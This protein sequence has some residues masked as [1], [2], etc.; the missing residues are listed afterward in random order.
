MLDFLLAFARDACDDDAAT[1]GRRPAPRPALDTTIRGSVRVDGVGNFTAFGDG[2]VRVHYPRPTH[3]ALSGDDDG[4][5]ADVLL[6][7]ADAFRVR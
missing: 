7:N 1:G 4:A 2:R 3:R 5:V 6:P